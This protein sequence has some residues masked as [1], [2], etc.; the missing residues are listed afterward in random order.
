MTL[1]LVSFSLVFLHVFQFHEVIQHYSCNCVSTLSQEEGSSSRKKKKKKKAQ[2]GLHVY[3]WQLRESQREQVAELRR[4]FEE[5]KKRVANM[6][7][8]RR[9]KPF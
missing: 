9:F 7:A 4:K 3:P 8:Q 1:F 5:D 6:R 2:V